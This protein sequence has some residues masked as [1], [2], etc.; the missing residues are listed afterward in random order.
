MRRRKVETDARHP[1]AVLTIIALPIS[2][3]ALGLFAVRF[4]YRT[5][6]AE[7]ALIGLARQIFVRIESR[8][9]VY[10][11]WVV[12]VLGIAYF[13]FKISRIFSERSRYAAVRA[14]LTIF[15]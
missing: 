3:V 5:I 4:A 1:A 11:S 2:L 15:A 14:T 6:G 7:P 10:C 12:Q 13:I 8:A 9:G